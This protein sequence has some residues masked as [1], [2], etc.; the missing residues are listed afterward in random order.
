[1][2]GTIFYNKWE[3][4]YLDFKYIVE[5]SIENTKNAI[6]AATAHSN[7]DPLC[8]NKLVLNADNKNN[9]LGRSSCMS[10]KLNFFCYL[11]E[12]NIGSIVAH[13]DAS[14]FICEHAAD[15]KF[16][17]PEIDITYIDDGCKPSPV[18]PI[19]YIYIDTFIQ[20]AEKK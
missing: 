19:F 13:A 1:L 2:S 12:H 6:G 18:V 10:S 14:E 7:D 9:L 3:N 4:A 8:K 15:V 20:E 11:S 5:K 17:F 16:Y